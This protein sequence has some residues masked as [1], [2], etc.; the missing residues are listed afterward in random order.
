MIRII[1]VDEN[2]QLIENVSIHN[3]DFSK[4]AWCWID[5]N[6]PTEEEARELNTSL[7]FHP[8]AIEDCVYS[9]Q[10][11]KLDYYDDFSFF[12]THAPGRETYNDNEID[13]FL[14]DNFIVTFHY[15]N[16]KEINEI[17][18]Q[19]QESSDLSKWDEYRVFY[20]VMD[21]VVDDYF[22]IIAHLEEEINL[23]EEN[24]NDDPMDVL[25]ERLFELRH[26]LL[27]LRHSI[28]PI[29]DLFYR[30]L[31]SH[32]LPG[33]QDRR[34]YFMDIYDHLLKLSEMTN[35]NR[36]ITN[37]IRDNFISINSYQQNKVI[38]V[39]TVITSIFAPLTFIAGI[40]GMNFVNMP[41]LDWHYGYYIA[42]GVMG[43]ITIFMIFFFKK[44]GWFG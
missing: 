8:L 15:E 28:N 21:N 6:S 11:P 27:E 43:I 10:R 16:L 31:Y 38:Q 37:D 40:Y 41:E 29:R 35:S 14:G 32:R 42:L 18:H 25:L 24:P 26:Q 22:P 30:I 36:E 2:N 1:A 7:H 17:W 5:F 12:V 44:R 4:Y 23:V 19:L 39:L 13:F 20:E 34:E 33:I 3:I 9:M